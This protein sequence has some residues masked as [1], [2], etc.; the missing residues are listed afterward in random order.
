MYLLS[1]SE[2]HSLTQAK[3]ERDTMVSSIQG[4]VNGGQVNH[5]EIGE[6]GRVVIKPNDISASNKKEPTEK[7][8]PT[9]R[10][11]KKTLGIEDVLQLPLG[12]KE[13]RTAFTQTDNPTSSSTQMQTENPLSHTHTQTD[14]KTTQMK[15][16]SVQSNVAPTTTSSFPSSASIGTQTV[17]LSQS[18]ANVTPISLPARRDSLPP[19]AVEDLVSQKINDIERRYRSRSPL[20][21]RSPSPHPTQP[22]PQRTP[23]PPPPTQ[24]ASESPLDLVRDK[25]REINAPVK[26]AQNL[27]R[28][29]QERIDTLNGTAKQRRETTE[30]TSLRRSKRTVKRKRFDEYDTDKKTKRTVKKRGRRREIFEEEEEEPIKKKYKKPQGVKRKRAEEEKGATIHPTDKRR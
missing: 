20:V 17:P 14:I 7:V 8:K 15:N 3:N 5:I 28:V 2:Y 26:P 6:G 23:S 4:D 24:R 1:R 13:M 18:K 19:P 12:P 22:S 10:A 29:I 25:I 11:D 21:R 16:A 27:K 9:P 30:S